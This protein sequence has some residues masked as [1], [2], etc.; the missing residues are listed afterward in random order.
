MTIP[1]EPK[2]KVGKSIQTRSDGHGKKFIRFLLI[3]VVVMFALAMSII[4]FEGSEVHSPLRGYA[5]CYDT[6]AVKIPP[7]GG[8]L[9]KYHC[10]CNDEWWVREKGVMRAILRQAVIFCLLGA[11]LAFLGAAGYTSHSAVHDMLKS[12]QGGLE[13]RRSQCESAFHGVFPAPPAG[14][15]MIVPDPKSGDEPMSG[16]EC[17]AMFGGYKEWMINPST[18]APNMRAPFKESMDIAARAMAY[19]W[20]YS[21]MLLT[22]LIA[23][24]WFAMYGFAA[25]FAFWIL[26][27]LIYFAVKG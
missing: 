2:E 13:Y 24:L 17:H 7:D 18:L 25:G 27:R 5:S 10:T 19:D 21:D 26:Y 22:P 16:N 8:M 11:T 6:G 4:A 14:P 12:R 23:G 15:W 20:D 9:H 1:K 3:C